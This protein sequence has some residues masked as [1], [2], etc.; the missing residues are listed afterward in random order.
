[1]D[2]MLSPELGYKWRLTVFDGKYICHER[3]CPIDVTTIT[4]PLPPEA[5]MELA[6]ERCIERIERAKELDNERTT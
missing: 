3:Y 5:W 1:M 6:Y 2:A 4:M